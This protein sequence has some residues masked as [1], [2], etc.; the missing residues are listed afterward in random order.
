MAYTSLCLLGRGLGGLR[1]ALLSWEKGSRPL[2]LRL[3]VQF[4]VS[5][6]YKRMGQICP[7][8]AHPKP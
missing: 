4:S 6:T 3:G 8:G 5:I 2:I 7:L 1:Q